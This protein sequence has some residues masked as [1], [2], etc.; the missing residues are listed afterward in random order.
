MKLNELLNSDMRTIGGALR[1]GLDWWRAE[2]AG[3]LPSRSIDSTQKPP[4]TAILVSGEDLLLLRDGRFDQSSKASEKFSGAPALIPGEESLVRTLSVPAMTQRDLSAMLALDGDRYFPMPAGTA[5]FSARISSTDADGMMTVDAA[6]WPIHRAQRVADAFAASSL[7]PSHVRLANQDFFPDSRFDFLPAMR[8][9]RMIPCAGQGAKLWWTIVAFMFVVNLAMIAWRD[10]AQLES[11]EA[12]VDAQRP[13]ASVAQR[14]VKQMRDGQELTMR[15]AHERAG[16]DAV[17]ILADVTRAVPDGAW[18]QRYSFEQ[19]SLRL[20]GYR[21]NSVD[22]AA[23]LRRL[24]RFS[25]V[26][27][28]QSDQAAVVA[29]GQPFDLVAE[30]RSN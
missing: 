27:S 20:S 3:M 6:A 2:L 18:V 15:S 10:S 8:D 11:L 14:I 21:L 23:A 26:K 7:S 19:N 24:P 16:R 30:L 17:G 1:K 9:Q 4:K 5:L 13:A 28:A 22:V 25:S 29:D 12:L